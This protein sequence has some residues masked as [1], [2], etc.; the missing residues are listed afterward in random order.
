MLTLLSIRDIVLIDAADLAFEPGLNALTGETGAG[1]SILLD[2]LGLATGAR[3]D[4]RLVRH[5]RPQGTVTA[6]FRPERGHGA[7]TALDEAGLPRDQ[8]DQITLRRIVGAEGPSRA[9][10]NDQPVSIALLQAVGSALV[11]IHGQH[12]ERGLLNPSGHRALIDQFGGLGE[13]VG[14]V[15]RAYVAWRE[16][17]RS[18]DDRREALAQ[19]AREAEYIAHVLQELEALDPQEGEEDSLSEARARAMAAEKITDDLKDAEKALAGDTGLEGRLNAVLRRLE[20]S[21]AGATDLLEAPVA[22]IDRALTEIAEARSAVAEALRAGAHDPA[23]LAATEERLFALRAMARKHGVRVDQLPAL[24][25]SF[26]DQWAA[27]ETGEADLKALDAETRRLG[28]VFQ[29][30]ATA[31]SARRRAAAERLDAAVAEDLSPLKLDKAKFRTSVTSLAPEQ[32]GPEGLDRVSFEIATNTGA[33]FGP[34]TDIASG[35]ELSRFILALKVALAAQGSPRTLIFDEIDRGVGG[36][37]ADAVGER[38]ARLAQGPDAQVLAVTHSPQVAARARHHWHIEKGHD[39]DQML[40]RVALLS[41]EA[42]LEEVARM[43]S[44][45]EV[46]AE[47]R[48]AAARLLALPDGATEPPARRTARRP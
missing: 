13:E 3:A 48:A 2:S 19:A 21:G 29:E 39:G 44:G 38:L 24:M 35:G 32:A 36:A 47:A 6:V 46:T 5:G 17:M 16:A 30:A 31:L 10:I 4:R 11:E 28:D 41:P 14:A 23:G 20:K 40:T 15:T 42:R 1:K 27:L 9:F 34:L 7:L 26:R 25:A 8:D 37:V 22:A 18:R 45:S 43:L 12:D 33:P